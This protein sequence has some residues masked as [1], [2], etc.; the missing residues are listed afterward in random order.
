MKQ[1][2]I[3]Q[4]YFSVVIKINGLYSTSEAILQKVLCL[5]SFNNT[6]TRPTQYYI[7][8]YILC[9]AVEFV[10]LICIPFNSAECSLQDGVVYVH[11]INVC[12]Q[13]YVVGQLNFY[14][15]Y[16]FLLTVASVGQCYVCTFN[17]LINW[18]IQIY[19]VGQLTFCCAECRM[20]LCMYIQ[21]TD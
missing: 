11:S 6:S 2:E 4:C 3:I 10:Q 9:R 18:C 5:Y 13:R 21:S 12:I 1:L 7:V 17:Q 19:I 20:V 14:S 15:L 16:A 8:Y